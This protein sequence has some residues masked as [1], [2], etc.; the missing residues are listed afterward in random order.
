MNKKQT[1]TFSWNQYELVWT[2]SHVSLLDLYPNIWITAWQPRLIWH[3]LAPKP[4]E[5]KLKLQELSGQITPPEP[6]SQTREM[7]V[8]LNIPIFTL[9]I[10]LLRWWSRCRHQQS[11][12]VRC[13]KNKNKGHQANSLTFIPTQWKHIIL[14]TALKTS[15][16]QHFSSHNHTLWNCSQVPQTSLLKDTW[17]LKSMQRCQ[18]GKEIPKL[19]SSNNNTATQVDNAR[20]A[21]TPGP[22]PPPNPSS[23][24][25]YLSSSILPVKM[26][27]HELQVDL[28]D[29]NIMFTTRTPASLLLLAVCKVDCS[30]R[31]APSIVQTVFWTLLTLHNR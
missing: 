5:N 18:A 16:H 13:K 31:I 25:Q 10:N 15:C 28:M 21:T 9:T 23:A 12:G 2:V 30:W 26:S 3:L 1:K 19:N 11:D 4:K 20:L 29:G 27:T 14:Y 24:A 8:W 6:R 22:P 17:V 7:M